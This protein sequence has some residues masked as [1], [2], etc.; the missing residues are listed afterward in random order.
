MPSK[1]TVDLLAA[2]AKPDF[3]DGTQA[4]RGEDPEIF[5]PERAVEGEPAIRIC[6]RCRLA[7]P[8]LLWALRTGQSFGI[9]GATTP[10]QRNKLQKGRRR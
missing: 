3:L 5:Y 1:T 9:W 2:A 6:R 7:E 4:C 10:R 8:C